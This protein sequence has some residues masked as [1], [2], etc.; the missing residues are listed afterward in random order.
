MSAHDNKVP[1]PGS[2]IYVKI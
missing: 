1:E 2:C